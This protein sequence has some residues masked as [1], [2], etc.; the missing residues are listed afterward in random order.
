M[1]FLFQ[2]VRELVSEI[3]SF[4]ICTLKLRHF[5]TYSYKVLLMT[6][7]TGYISPRDVTSSELSGSRLWCR[8]YY[9]SLDSL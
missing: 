8:Y 1:N 4:W 2:S 3:S 9:L 6:V 7:G 5:E